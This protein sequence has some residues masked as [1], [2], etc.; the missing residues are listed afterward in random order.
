MV[1]CNYIWF[2]RTC[3][4]KDQTLTM[5]DQVKKDSFKKKNVMFVWKSWKSK[6]AQMESEI[7]WN[8]YDCAAFSF[9]QKKSSN[10]DCIKENTEVLIPLTEKKKEA[11]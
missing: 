4:T 5:K 10:K 11:Y 3:K 6:A 9:S 1:K 7:Y 2:F 8:I